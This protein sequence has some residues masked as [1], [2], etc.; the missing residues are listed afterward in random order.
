MVSAAVI[1]ALAAVGW[2]VAVSPVLGVRTVAVHGTT[3]LSDTQVRSAAAVPPGAPLL[4][5]D[6]A[7]VRRRVQA[8]PDVASA[9]VAVTYPGT[10]T[11]SVVERVAV[12]ALAAP[13]RLVDGTGVAYRTTADPPAGVPSTAAT[14]PDLQVAAAVAAVLPPVD[15][16]LVRSIGVAGGGSVSL[17]LIDGR[18]V[19][20]GAADRSAEKA[21]LLAALLKPPAPGA[22]PVMAGTEIDLR[23]PSVVVTR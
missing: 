6:T 16:S 23:D 11:V 7:A 9:R 12:L 15:R 10:V 8:L 3:T 20:W 1:G 4:R 22:A 19:L 2:V 17:L 14:G 13:T 18:T 21:D 5:L